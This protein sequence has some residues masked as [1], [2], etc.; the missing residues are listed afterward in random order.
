M[1]NLVKLIVFHND[2]TRTFQF[3][4]PW[5]QKFS[6]QKNLHNKHPKS[7]TPSLAQHLHIFIYIYITLYIPIFL[8]SWIFQR[9][10][11]VKFHQTIREIAW[12]NHQT[13]QFVAKKPPVFKQTVERSK[14][15]RAPTNNASG[16]LLFDCILEPGSNVHCWDVV[17][18]VTKTL[19]V[20]VHLIC[21]CC[22]R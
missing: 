17:L 15:V 19:R 16:W 6:I 3:H 11:V 7:H 20:L 13:T 2:Q 4:K 18:T 9:L 12:K 22:E 5:K 1:F 21:S 10:L 8:N 14:I